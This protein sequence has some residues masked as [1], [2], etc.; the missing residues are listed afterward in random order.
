MKIEKTIKIF[1]K[2]LYVYKNKKYP[3]YILS[4]GLCYVVLIIYDISP[5]YSSFCNMINNHYKNYLNE[6]YY[7]YPINNTKKSISFRINFLKKEIVYLENLLK[8]G[9]T[10]I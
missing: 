7:L 6:K 10:H 9:Y 4:K 8:K 2:L 5:F 3:D 1:K